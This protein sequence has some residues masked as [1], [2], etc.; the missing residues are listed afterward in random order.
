MKWLGEWC[1]YGEWNAFRNHEPLVGNTNV[2][3]LRIFG[4][5]HALGGLECA[6]DGHVSKD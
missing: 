4:P 2:V 3:E 6:R 1:A 5:Y